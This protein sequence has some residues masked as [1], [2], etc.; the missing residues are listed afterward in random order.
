MD[1]LETL[2]GIRIQKVSSAHSD[3][4]YLMYHGS[5]HVEINHL[6]YTLISILQ[7]SSNIQDASDRYSSIVNKNISP[8]DLQQFIEKKIIPLFYTESTTQKKQAF[9]FEYSIVPEQSCNKVA[10]K[11][12]FLY[13]SSFLY[14]L[15]LIS[16]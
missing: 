13:R 10:D 9:L 14:P 4:M 5:V 11:L 1:K 16:A 12:K 8:S 3:N 2:R 6:T 15:L 7:T